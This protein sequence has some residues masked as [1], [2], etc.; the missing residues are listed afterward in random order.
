MH[1][2]EKLHTIFDQNL[3]IN[4]EITYEDIRANN[5]KKVLTLLTECAKSKELI[6]KS[7]GRIAFTFVGFEESEKVDMIEM[8]EMYRFLAGIRRKFPYF[9]YFLSGVNQT[10]PMFLAVNAKAVVIRDQWGNFEDVK[11]DPKVMKAITEKAI[12]DVLELLHGYDI[13]G[14]KIDNFLEKITCELNSYFQPPQ[15]KQALVSDP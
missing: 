2:A 12:K 15:P 13:N 4:Q 8:P 3:M 10:L 9:L 5:K 11:Y 6:E 7:Q 1:N 14:Q